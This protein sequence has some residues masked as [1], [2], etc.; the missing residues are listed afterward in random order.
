MINRLTKLRIEGFKSIKD[1]GELELGP[2]NVLIGA[3]G[4]GKSAFV[5]AFKMLNFIFHREPAIL[6]GEKRLRRID[7]LLWFEADATDSDVVRF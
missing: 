1:A 4:S 5:S 7:S 2:V 6:G 3:D